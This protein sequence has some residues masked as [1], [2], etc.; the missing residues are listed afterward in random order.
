MIRCC[1]AG[2]EAEIMGQRCGMRLG[3]PGAVAAWEQ[4][5]PRVQQPVKEAVLV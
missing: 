2:G 3:F 5:L 1:A 4:Q